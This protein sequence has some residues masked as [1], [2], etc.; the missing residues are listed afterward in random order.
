[1]L[2]ERAAVAQK[3]WGR[4]REGEEVCDVERSRT[5]AALVED[6]HKVAASQAVEQLAG[7]CL[8]L[9]LRVG[10]LFGVAFQVHVLELHVPCYLGLPLFCM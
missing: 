8:F 5:R 2:R 10:R 4:T 6:N 3:A 9:R 7:L 1:M